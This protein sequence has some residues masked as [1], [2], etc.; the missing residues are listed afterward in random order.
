MYRSA[1]LEMR[2]WEKRDERNRNDDANQQHE[3]Q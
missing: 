1:H 3:K 2:G